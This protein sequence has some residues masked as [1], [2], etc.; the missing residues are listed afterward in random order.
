MK[1]VLLVE[2][3]YSVREY[4]KKAIAWKE[5]GYCVIG[6]AVMGSEALEVRKRKATGHYDYRYSNAA[7]EWNR[8]YSQNKRRRLCYKIC[9]VKFL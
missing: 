7:N 4:L 3:D 5:N 6:E 2:D 1:T 8:T 9:S